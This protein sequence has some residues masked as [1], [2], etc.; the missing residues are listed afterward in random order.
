MIRNCKDIKTRNC[1]KEFSTLYHNT[2]MIGL[3][4]TARLI[5]WDYPTMMEPKLFEGLFRYD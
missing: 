1:F 3:I 4:E 2:E 5:M